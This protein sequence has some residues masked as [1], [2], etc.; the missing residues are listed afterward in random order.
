MVDYPLHLVNENRA[1]PECAFAQHLPRTLLQSEGRLHETHQLQ[2]ENLLESNRVNNLAPIQAL[3]H[4][5]AVNNFQFQN[6]IQVVASFQYQ[7]LYA[8]E[9][10]VPQVI[11][12][13]S[14]IH[15]LGPTSHFQF[16]QSPAS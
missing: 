12:P 7:R 5:I 4:L 8:C 1:P 14:Q 11:Y 13:L 9:C 2:Q 16:Q 3:V 6:K 15:Q 10:V